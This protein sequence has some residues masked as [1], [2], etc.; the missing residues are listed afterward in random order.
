METKQTAVEWLVEK[1]S[2]YNFEM[3][4][5]RNKYIPE[6]LK[7]EADQIIDAYDNGA[8][9]DQEGK[10]HWGVQY[11]EETFKQK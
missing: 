9:Y 3:E 8:D 11:Y 1:M 4:C 10:P 6:A 5:V 7:I 2:Q